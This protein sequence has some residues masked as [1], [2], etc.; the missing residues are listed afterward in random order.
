MTDLEKVGNH[1]IYFFMVLEMYKKL[2]Y[3]LNNTEIS[4]EGDSIEGLPG[5]ILINEG[6]ILN[7]N[8]NYYLLSKKYTKISNSKFNEIKPDYLN[9]IKDYDHIFKADEGNIIIGHDFRISLPYLVY[10]SSCE[11]IKPEP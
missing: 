10:I 2:G 11:L 6:E 7:A 5:Y 9:S 3:N 8:E 4:F 1:F